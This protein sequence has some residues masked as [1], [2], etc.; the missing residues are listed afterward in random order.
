VNKSFCQNKKAKDSVAIKIGAHQTSKKKEHKPEETGS[1]TE[2]RS[3]G[4]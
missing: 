3:T 4:A 2:D 1:A